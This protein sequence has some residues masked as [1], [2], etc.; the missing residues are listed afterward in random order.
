MKASQIINWGIIGPG[1]IA[2]KF[3]E[4]LKRVPGCTLGAVAS[5]SYERAKE[6]ASRFD[7]P[8]FYGSYDEIVNDH[9]VDIVYIATPHNLHCANTLLCL[10]HGKAVLCEKPFAINLKEAEQMVLS[11]RKNGVFLM[12]AF[13]SR[14]NPVM[15]M[16]KSITDTD[17]LGKIKMLKADFG[18][19][20]V[21]NPEGRVFNPLLG[22]GSL[23]DVGV[24]PLFLASLLL[25]KP[26]IIRA[27]A[28]LTKSGIDE[29]CGITLKYENGAIAIL[30]SSVVA[31]TESEAQITFENGR[32]F[33]PSRWYV[34]KKAQVIQADRTD[35]W[36]SE[37]F[38]GFGYQ[39]EAMEA[40]R[41]LRESRIESPLLQHNFSL[42]LLSTMDEVRK[43][44]GIAYPND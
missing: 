43:L 36:I 3:A 23:L 32:I 24:Y 42:L 14:F 26:E 4:D 44:C 7:A 31:S 20:A 34:P 28:Q 30:S 29:S 41:C 18:F 25:G 40:N 27:A 38:E 2:E 17:E 9:N 16:I 1:H 22:G 35:R 37:E 33:V 12:E 21:Y 39:F 13:W 6:F 5:R 11:S 10:S 8:R 19:K 15:Q